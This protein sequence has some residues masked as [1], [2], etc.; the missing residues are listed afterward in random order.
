MKLA[1]LMVVSGVLAGIATAQQPTVL[2]QG[3]V[4]NA[5]SYSLTNAPGSLVAV[6][7]TNFSDKVLLASSVPLSTTLKDGNVNV[8]VTFDGISA[9]LDFAA[10]AQVNAQ[11]PWGVNTSSGTVMVVVTRGSN[12][13]APQPLQVAKF[14]PSVFTVTASGTGY[15][16]ATIGNS[17]TVAAPPGKALGH[18][19]QPIPR[20]KTLVIYANGLGPVSPVVPDGHAG[21][22]KTTSSVNV[23]FGGDAS[24]NGG[25]V[26][27]AAFAGASPQYPG[28]NQVN[29]SVPQNAPTGD[30]ISIQL[31]VGGVTSTNQVVVAIQ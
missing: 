25:V 10:Q 5:A 28:V 9:P 30:S 16:I 23:I 14:S 11:L 24:G 22:S 15:A 27:P 31:Q 7:G 29:V 4:K 26:V 17:A 6:F 20:G 18:P 8:S 21:G 12:S 19:S 1:R 3:G 2:S 13:S